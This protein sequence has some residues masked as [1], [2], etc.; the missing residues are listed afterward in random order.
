MEFNVSL[1]EF[2]LLLGWAWIPLGLC[3]SY[4]LTPLPNLPLSGLWS[5]ASSWG[6]HTL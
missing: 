1:V 5:L 2:P 6:P 4:L 3:P